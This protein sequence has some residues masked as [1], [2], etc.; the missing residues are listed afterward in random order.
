VDEDVDGD[1]DADVKDQDDVD[2]NGDFRSCRPPRGA[3]ICS[4]EPSE[5]GVVCTT[6]RLALVIACVVGALALELPAA[7]KPKGAVSVRP[8]TVHGGLDREIIRRIFM[9]HL[10]EVREC[11]GKGLAQDSQLAGRVLARFTVT[12][13]G[14]AYSCKVASST[15]A[16]PVVEKC[17]V[18]AVGSW[19]FPQNMCGCETR[20]KVALNFSR[21][22]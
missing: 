7:A 19:D 10:D 18:K 8:M 4:L 20:I 22:D 13:S 11:Y 5:L 12:T 16:S 6:M 2:V 21:D 9:R 3:G 17:V 14:K 1:E 15:L